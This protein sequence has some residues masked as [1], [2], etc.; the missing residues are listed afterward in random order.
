MLRIE[1]I[2][3]AC[4]DFPQVS[5]RWKL[6]PHCYGVTAV[7]LGLPLPPS[8]PK[9]SFSSATLQIHLKV[10]VGLQLLP[11][12]HYTCVTCVYHLLSSLCS[13]WVVSE[14][15]LWCLVC[16]TA[17]SGSAPTTSLHTHS[18]RA[19][20]LTRTRLNHLCFSSQTLISAPP[21]G[22]GERHLGR[23]ASTH[24]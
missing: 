21:S 16:A 20:G 7:S 13:C 24:G 8:L 6:L 11:L 18:P 14:T 19:A 3:S 5:V 23:F 9:C 15:P 10:A 4:S 2:L 1:E 22:S 12:S 17:G